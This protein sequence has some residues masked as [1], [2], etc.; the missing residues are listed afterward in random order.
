MNRS[1]ITEARH[2]L[3]QSRESAGLCSYCGKNPPKD[4]RIG[5]VECLKKKVSGTLSYTRAHKDRAAL[6]RKRIR[7]AA[8]DK[9]GGVCVCCKESNFM[10]LTIDHVNNDGGAERK[11]ESGRN[12]VSSTSMYLFLLRSDVRTDLQVLC[13]NCNLGKY[14]NGGVCPHIDPPPNDL[15]PLKDHRTDKSFN[16]GCKTNWPSDSDLLEMIANDG[17]TGVSNRLNVTI[18]A[19]T[20]RLKRRGLEKPARRPRA[21]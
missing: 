6:Y 2:R 10:L 9:Y 18:G 17:L 21:E 5:C 14:A 4:G 1:K 3:W 8:I 15:R 11:A 20:G 19:V 12:S 13:Y 7:K 16:I